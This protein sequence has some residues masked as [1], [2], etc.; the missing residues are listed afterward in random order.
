M[1]RWKCVHTRSGKIR[2]E[3][4]RDNMREAGSVTEMVQACE[5]EEMC[6]TSVRRCERLALVGLRRE[7]G[8]P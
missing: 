2:N 8:R 6:R 4:I 1:L 3:D 5:E 7:R